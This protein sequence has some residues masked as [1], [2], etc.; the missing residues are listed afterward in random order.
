MALNSLFR[1]TSALVACAAVSFA[2]DPPGPQTS[3]PPAKPLVAAVVKPT[4]PIDSIPPKIDASAVKINGRT[5]RFAKGDTLRVDASGAMNRADVASASASIDDGA[6]TPLVAGKAVFFAVPEGA[7]RVRIVA[8]DKA[9]N[10]SAPAE[11]AII[12]DRTSPDVSRAVVTIGNGKGI[13]SSAKVVAKVAGITDATGLKT[14]WYKMGGTAPKEM[15]SDSISLQLTRDGVDTLA[16]WAED[17]A[18]N[19]S[20]H[21]CTAIMRDSKAPSASA[22]VDPLWSNGPHVATWSFSEPMDVA[23][24]AVVKLDSV[25]VEAQWIGRDTLRANIVVDAA[26]VNGRRQL[27]LASAVDLAGNASARLAREITVDNRAPDFTAKNVTVNLGNLSISCDSA[28]VTIV[29]VADPSGVARYRYAVD[30]KVVADTPSA[31]V[32]LRKLV[33]GKRELTITVAD[34]A[35]NVSAP[36][37][38]SL[39]VDASRPGLRGAVAGLCD[40]IAKRIPLTL[41]F[42]KA[43]DTTALL[44]LSVQGGV[45]ADG[46]WLDTATYRCSYDPDARGTIDSVRVTIKGGRDRGKMAMGDLEAVCVIGVDTAFHLARLLAAGGNHAAAS[47][48][49]QRLSTANA[50]REDVAE[51][52]SIESREAKDRSGERQAMERLA[53]LRPADKVL[54]KSLVNLTSQM[55]DRKASKAWLKQLMVA[56]GKLDDVSSVDY[57]REGRSFF[58]LA[59][60][61]CILSSKGDEAAA[62]VAEGVMAANAKDFDAAREA[63]AGALSLDDSCI[64]ATYNVATL[65]LFEGVPLEAE[66]ALS[67]CAAAGERYAG[68]Y[69]VS[70][71]MS[72]KLEAALKT[73]DEQ[74]ISLDDPAIAGVYGVVLIRS[75]KTSEALP[76]LEKASA[77]GT[78]QRINY[79]FGLYTNKDYK[80]ALAVFNACGAAAGDTFPEI[81]Y[82]KALAE[83]QLDEKDAAVAHLQAAVAIQPVYLDAQLKLGELLMK[84]K[85]RAGARQALTFAARADSTSS[86]AH[87]ALAAMY[88]ETGETDLA[89]TE[90]MNAARPPQK[91]STAMT[92]AVE[93]FKNVTQDSSVSWL[94]VG[95]AEALTTEMNRFSPYRMLERLQIEAIT[96][97]MAL[98]QA[99]GAD[100]DDSE[101]RK[102]LGAKAIVTGSYQSVGT[103]LRVDGRLINVQTGVII[104]T[105]SVSGTMYELSK[106]QR[107]LALTLSG[108]SDALELSELPGGVSAEAQERMALAKKALYGGDAEAAKL[109]ADQ[110]LL[111]DPQALSLAGSM[112]VAMANE[113]RG[114]SMAVLQF[115]NLTGNV[116]DGGMSSGIQEALITNL[117][118]A[119]NLSIVERSQIDKLT[120]EMGLGQSGLVE[121][122]SASTVGGM[123]AAGVLLTGGFQGSGNNLRITA[124]LLDVVTGEVLLATDVSGKRDALFALEDQL[125]VRILQALK[126][127]PSV[128]TAAQID[129]AQKRSIDTTATPLSQEPD[130]LE[131]SATVSSSR[132]SRENTLSR[133]VTLFI[134]PFGIHLRNN[135]ATRNYDAGFHFLNKMFA[136]DGQLDLSR[137]DMSPSRHEPSDVVKD[138]DPAS[139]DK[140]Y[141]SITIGAGWNF[142]RSWNSDD[143]RVKFYQ[144]RAGFKSLRAPAIAQRVDS[145]PP[146]L[147]GVTYTGTDGNVTLNV[148]AGIM[149]AGLGIAKKKDDDGSRKVLRYSFDFLYAPILDYPAKDN[150]GTDYEGYINALTLQR[151]GGRFGIELIQSHRFG[152]RWLFETGISPGV[153]DASASTISHLFLG[154][155][156]GVGSS[157]F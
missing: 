37:A 63:F 10:V 88:R 57:R 110:A 3:A 30:G 36:V 140:I 47:A 126:E 40:T 97:R 17:S 77:T 2:Q 68:N 64:E 155:K 38:L 27:V 69:A 20:V 14:T 18:G 85:D 149:Y 108:R 127:A 9:G 118:K 81:N 121:E 138:V 115:D 83:L 11:A 22:V 79:A 26:T 72:G 8:Q 124:K 12:V 71:A 139:V 4:A 41:S 103:N 54:L 29:E 55:G 132:N 73:F 16:V 151:I 136:V 128:D 135:Y 107:T 70:L 145:L 5:A 44:A 34:G 45:L 87:Q 100:A 95:M 13:T 51:L 148:T 152:F 99:T 157:W 92:V 114:K 104:T 106:M 6:P 144:L 105:A 25:A 23:V 50:Y 32:M 94:S 143:S 52:W 119:G 1:V 42:T 120:A 91:D 131:S 90:S 96:K 98:K 74:K 117:R 101:L 141:R 147:G 80:K 66:A 39:S 82:G 153:R 15:T 122:S 102:A 58:Q 48:L 65:Q 154:A 137:N 84:S 24:P 111:I 156:I 61:A 86:A 49:L 150:D 109:L 46:Q 76:Y 93:Q 133:R 123:L 7:H 59:P 60:G 89:R 21:V 67:R 62:L 75:G 28:L 33:D 35:N 113:G 129:L 116:S 31:K 56:D 78:V 134:S 43:M 130:V 112:A 53:K 142:A 146:Y 125:A 19:A